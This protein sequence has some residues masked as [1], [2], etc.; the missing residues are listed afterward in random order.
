M[1]ERLHRLKLDVVTERELSVEW[2]KKAA[3][4]LKAGNE[5][6]ARQALARMLE[7]VSAAA[8]L[9]RECATLEGLP[10]DTTSSS[11]SVD[12]ALASLRQ[13]LGVVPRPVLRAS[14]G[15]NG[16]V[17]ALLALDPKKRDQ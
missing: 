12:A 11:P 7:H 14:H 15:F 1:S 2:E 5:D 6:L 16:L 9:A 3:L 17:A 13:K 10:S 4:A 8:E